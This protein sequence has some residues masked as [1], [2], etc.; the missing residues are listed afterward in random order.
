M[1]II[2]LIYETDTFHGDDPFFC[3]VYSEWN[4]TEE[5]RPLPEIETFEVELL[6]DR[7]KVTIPGFEE[8]EY[9]HRIEYQIQQVRSKR[10]NHETRSRY[11]PSNMRFKVIKKQNLVESSPFCIKDLWPFEAN[12]IRVRYWSILFPERNSSRDKKTKSQYR[13]SRWHHT[14]QLMPAPLNFHLADDQKEKEETLIST[15]E[16][17]DHEQLCEWIEAKFFKNIPETAEL[18]DHMDEKQGAGS[19]LNEIMST[20]SASDFR[21]TIPGKTG[22]IWS[23]EHE[24][25]SV[26]PIIL[27]VIR[28]S[29]L[30]GS[31]I[32]L[33]DPTVYVNE[34]MIPLYRALSGNSRTTRRSSAC[35]VL[36]E[37]DFE[38]VMW[39]LRQSAFEETQHPIGALIDNPYCIYIWVYFLKKP[40]LHYAVQQSNDNVVIQLRP[41]LD[42]SEVHLY[43]AKYFARSHPSEYD[44]SFYLC[45]KNNETGKFAFLKVDDEWVRFNSLKRK[46]IV[47][48]AY[49]EGKGT[50]R[51]PS[52]DAEIRRDLVKKLK[53]MKDWKSLEVPK[54]WGFG[55]KKGSNLPYFECLLQ[56]CFSNIGQRVPLSACINVTES[57]MKIQ[58]EKGKSDEGLRMIIAKV[59]AQKRWIRSFN[60]L[61]DRTWCNLIKFLFHIYWIP[62]IDHSQ[63]TKLFNHNMRNMDVLQQLLSGEYGPPKRAIAVLRTIIKPVAEQFIK[64]ITLAIDKTQQD[65]SRRYQYMLW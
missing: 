63:Q 16:G 2:S 55:K 10:D 28:Q 42:T 34:V 8:H 31:D 56:F 1:Q 62:F 13:W 44:G 36:E 40:S 59:E 32:V 21:N 7:F 54:G 35:L 25:E 41:C 11:R 17:F 22:T 37:E 18:R 61:N 48:R 20:I 24:M 64:A 6:A 29:K 9:C 38:S 52:A 26:F 5:M 49:N 39:R 27:Q 43:Y 53:D 51:S 33:R 47:V 65:I 3:A 15:V 45:E 50:P 58:T 46:H 12:R 23:T 4:K 57:M 19:S 30:T 14:R 60:D